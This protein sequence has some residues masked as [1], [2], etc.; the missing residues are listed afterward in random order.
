MI[1][2][3]IEFEKAAEK[4]ATALGDLSQALDVVSQTPCFTTPLW[5]ENPSV[6]LSINPKWCELIASGE[7]TIEIRKTR[8]K[9]ETPFKCYIYCTKDNFK[10]IFQSKPYLTTGNF[11]VCNGKVIGEFICDFIAE[12]EGE[13]WD[14]KTYEEIKEKYEPSDFA[15]YGEYEYQIIAQNGEANW[16]CKK[17]CLDWE[18]LRKYI[19]QGINDFYGWHI[20]DLV[21]Y[22]TPKELREF[23]KTCKETNL[24]YP[25]NCNRCGWNIDRKSVV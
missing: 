19:G 25:D 4:V 15:E 2:S 17:S 20:S 8:P 6:M 22:D 10:S 3:F 12:F 13:F 5:K 18:E 11:K 9:I 7:K 14:N 21:I 24:C 1:E 16:L 23:K